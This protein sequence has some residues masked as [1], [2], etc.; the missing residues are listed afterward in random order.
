MG[1]LEFRLGVDGRGAQSLL[2]PSITD[3]WGRKWAVGLDDCDVAPLPGN[4]LAKLLAHF[5]RQVLARQSEQAVEHSM[6]HSIAVSHAV[7]HAVSHS[8]Q[9]PQS[10]VSHF[11]QQPDQPEQSPQPSTLPLTPAVERAIRAT[12]PGTPGFRNK[13]LL[14]F[15]RHLKAIPE[16][17]SRRA[18]ELEPYVEEWHRRALPTIGTP[19]FSETWHDFAVAWENVKYAL[20]EGPLADVYAAGL[21]HIP[22]FAQRYRLPKLRNLVALCRELQLQAGPQPFWL[23]CRAAA[24][25]LGV[26]PTTANRWL[27]KLQHDGVLELVTEG[28]RGR[29]A[30]YYYRGEG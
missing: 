5:G 21:K 2:P 20:G 8:S 27:H 28:S 18:E 12:L 24:G 15:A 25:M 29:A 22:E 4:V 7:F 13:Q 11:P 19:D 3:S 23:A 30:E 17:A 9:Q 6:E 10:A 1:D 26:G 14:Q 16:L